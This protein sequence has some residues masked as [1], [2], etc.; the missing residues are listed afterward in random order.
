[1]N[2]FETFFDY[3]FGTPNPKEKRLSQDTQT[4]GP[5]IQDPPVVKEDPVVVVQ[6]PVPFHDVYVAGAKNLTDL[7]MNRADSAMAHEAAMSAQEK[8]E[9]IEKQAMADIEAKR[10][11][12]ANAVVAAERAMENVTADAL[13]AAAAQIERLQD[14]IA[15]NGG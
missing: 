10:I 2:V 1:M 15:K 8:N 3:V 12:L 9:A 7:L 5:A 4:Q 6:D 14:F 11:D 13:D